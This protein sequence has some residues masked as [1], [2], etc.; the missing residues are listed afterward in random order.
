[1]LS[2]DSDLLTK[3]QI[4]Q[5]T[6]DELVIV[7]LEWLKKFRERAGILIKENTRQQDL[8][9]AHKQIG[10]LQEKIESITKE[11]NWSLKHNKF[12]ECEQIP[13]LKLEIEQRGSHR[14]QLV[15]D[16]K[17]YKNKV[18]ELQNTLKKAMRES[19]LQIDKVLAEKEHVMSRI[20]SCNV[21]IEKYRSEVQKLEVELTRKNNEIG[22]K[23]TDIFN[24]KEK[25]RLLESK[26]RSLEMQLKE[27][28]K[29]NKNLEKKLSKTPMEEA[30]DRTKIEFKAR[31]DLCPGVL[32]EERERNKGL[33]KRLLMKDRQVSKLL[34]KQAKQ[35][36]E[37]VVVKK[38]FDHSMSDFII[39]DLKKKNESL[40]GQIKALLENRERDQA[41]IKEVTNQLLKMREQYCTDRMKRET[42]EARVDDCI[43][44]L[45]P[46]DESKIETRSTKKPPGLLLTADKLTLLTA[47]RD[48]ICNRR[49]VL[50]SEGKIQPNFKEDFT[51]QAPLE[52][53][54]VPP[55]KRKSETPA[56]KPSNRRNSRKLSEKT[57]SGQPGCLSGKTDSR[58]P[59]SR[60]GTTD[61]NGEEPMLGIKGNSI[62]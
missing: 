12:L 62:L 4:R 44:L 1:M 20:P 21:K 10:L 30:I 58:Q 59:G 39:R 46:G 52:F 24:E 61:G 29:E 18:K 42:K 60:R 56:L 45:R 6:R 8:E 11:L 22:M 19:K 37:A 2:G 15:S 14:T 38:S 48:P 16:L 27:T 25:S 3:A 41:H 51:R 33:V 26:I 57:D 5:M 32:A 7:V 49:I 9:N 50:L 31:I 13:K 23:N 53:R 28:M 55:P 43:A 35:E 34:E 17:Q 47:Q 36:R 54:P 40:N